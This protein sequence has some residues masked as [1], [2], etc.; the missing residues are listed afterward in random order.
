MSKIYR[1]K[2][3]FTVIPLLRLGPY[4]VVLHRWKAGDADPDVHCHRWD[5]TSIVLWGSLRERRY[6]LVPGWN[7][8][9]HRCMPGQGPEP[10]PVGSCDAVLTSDHLILAPAVYTGTRHVFHQAESP[11]GALTLF[12]QRRRRQKPWSVVLRPV[13]GD[14]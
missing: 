3:G 6:D 11:D 9:C 8:H 7:W 10:A 12:I 5:F 4:R 1:H 13:T 14:E 2:L